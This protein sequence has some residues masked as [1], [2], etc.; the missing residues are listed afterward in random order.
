MN[1]SYHQRPF[2]LTIIIL[3]SMLL[4]LCGHATPIPCNSQAVI[5]YYLSPTPSG[6]EGF[7]ACAAD[8][9][10]LNKALREPRQNPVTGDIRVRL[11]DSTGTV[12]GLGLR[13]PAAIRMDTAYPLII[14]LHGGTGSERNDKGDS[15]FLMLEALADTFSLFLASPSANRFAPWWSPAGLLRILQTLRY[16]TL[17]YPINPDKVFLAGVS[18]GATGCYAAANTINA[19]FAGFIAVSGFGGMLPA[20]GMNLVPANLMLRP[21]YNVNAGRDRIYPIDLVKRFIADLKLQGVGIIE[22]VYDEE[23]H[24]FD[25]RARE[26]GTLAN[27]IRTWSRPES[28]H[29][30][31]TFVQGF[32]NLPDH[33]VGWNYSGGEAFIR[34]WW[35]HDTL[36]IRSEGLTSFTAAFAAT[37][38]REKI[39][40]LF[41]AQRNR[42]R[43]IAAAKSSWPFELLLMQNRCVPEYAPARFYTIV[44]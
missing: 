1:A 3:P 37:P 15:A 20:V 2:L 33:I 8:S 44:P 28:P 36:I 17:H 26:M 31:W 12:Y 11:T 32:P 34:A 13:T 7:H 43:K 27:F 16:M 38:L 5:D 40:C 39:T 4:V 18:D 30:A 42:T 24:G 35:R 29:C 23:E 9:A 10:V 14:Y 22:K 25:Y 6:F 41:P 19:P 21:I